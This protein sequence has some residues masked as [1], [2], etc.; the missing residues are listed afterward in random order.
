LGNG[1][2]DTREEDA[3][4]WPTHVKAP[5]LFA[6]EGEGHG[7]GEGLR[8]PVVQFGVLLVALVRAV[9]VEQGDCGK[10]KAEGLGGPPPPQTPPTSCIF[11]VK[12]AEFGIFDF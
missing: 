7:E 6:V 4:F 2:G 8:R 1:G 5:V 3:E 11:G 9:G 10:A 12:P